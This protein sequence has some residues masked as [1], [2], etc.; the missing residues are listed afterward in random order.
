MMPK[1]LRKVNW[2]FSR[3]RELTEWSVNNKCSKN[4]APIVKPN[5]PLLRNEMT[6][7]VCSSDSAIGGFYYVY[8]VRIS[9]ARA[10]GRKFK[11]RLECHSSQVVIL[12]ISALTSPAHP[13]PM[14]IAARATLHACMSRNAPDYGKLAAVLPHFRDAKNSANPP[15]PKTSTLKVTTHKFTN[16][17]FSHWTYVNIV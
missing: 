2:P 17:V 8:T 12:I 5:T 11:H 4:C 7:E 6:T 1:Q 3:Q 14:H 15:R 13:A 9:L 16:I 10:L